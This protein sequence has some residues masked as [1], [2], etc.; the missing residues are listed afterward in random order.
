MFS[1]ATKVFFG[2][3]RFAFWVGGMFFCGNMAKS[4]FDAFTG[5]EPEVIKEEQE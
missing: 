1:K 4:S 2:I 5:K 3:A